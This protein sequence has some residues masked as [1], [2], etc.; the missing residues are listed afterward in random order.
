MKQKQEDGFTIVELLITIVFL[1]IVAL[2]ISQLFISIG[3]IQAKTQRLDSATHAAK[4]QIESLR[5]N[6]YSSLTNGSTLDFSSELPDNLPNGQGTVQVS[7]PTPGLK[8]VDVTVTYL[9][10]SQNRDVALSSLVGI[11]GISQ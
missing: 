1:G 5:N 10:G 6:N 4:T 3:A 9:D 7:E 8:R 2:A 11:I